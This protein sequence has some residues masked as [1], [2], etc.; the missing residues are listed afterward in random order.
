M[1]NQD[2]AIAN[3]I[4]LEKF[5][6]I[7]ISGVVKDQNEKE[8]ISDSEMPFIQEEF[9]DFIDKDGKVKSWLRAR[10]L[11]SAVASYGF[12]EYLKTL[13]GFRGSSPSKL[14]PI[15]AM[16]VSNQ[17]G[18]SLDPLIIKLLREQRNK[19]YL[20]FSKEKLET[21]THVLNPT[22]D[23]TIMN[24]DTVFT[25]DELEKLRNILLEDA[26]ERVFGSSFNEKNNILQPKLHLLGKAPEI[27]MQRLFD[28]SKRHP[29]LRI[30]LSKGTLIWK[31][32]TEPSLFISKGSCYFNQLEVDS[33]DDS[34]RSK[35]LR[36]FYLMTKVLSPEETFKR[37]IKLDEKQDGG[38]KKVD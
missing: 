22:L 4:L 7:V 26:I 2:L 32:G 21:V 28:A 9:S 25:V 17:I 8:I 31:Y 5:K 33:N 36:Q 10:C 24:T 6:S 23:F 11:E 19:K 15:N 27:D 20:Q 14:A 35:I 38:N 16:L 29:K 13:L 34:G 37:Q 30:E 18:R 12:E 1:S 3:R